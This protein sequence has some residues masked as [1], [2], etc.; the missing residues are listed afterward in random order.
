[1]SQI[2]ALNEIVRAHG[3][4]HWEVKYCA[5][6]MRRE[7]TRVMFWTSDKGGIGMGPGPVK[8]CKWQQ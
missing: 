5:P 7:H 8:E 3:N 1:M 6:E 2:E 4:L